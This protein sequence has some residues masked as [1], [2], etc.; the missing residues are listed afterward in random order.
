[1]KGR[2]W[3]FEMEIESF[4]RWVCDLKEEIGGIC[5][6]KKVICVFGVR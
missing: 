5:E 4:K 2:F 3:V 6:N 1:M